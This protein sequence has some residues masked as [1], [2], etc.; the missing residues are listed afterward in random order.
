MTRES[1][2]SDIFFSNRKNNFTLNVYI[3]E[4]QIVIISVY[5][6][7]YIVSYMNPIDVIVLKS[8]EMHV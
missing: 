1:V 6:S 8:C 2:P 3:F 7:S 4:N 5:Y